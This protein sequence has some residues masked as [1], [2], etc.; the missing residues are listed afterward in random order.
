MKINRLE[1][2]D[3]FLEFQK[4]ANLI[5]EGLRECIEKRP[6]EYE[7]YPFYAFGHKRTYA[8]DEQCKLYND[9]LMCSILD[10]TYQRKFTDVLQMPNA[11]IIWIP[12]LT[13]PKAEP[14]SWLFK[15]YPQE[16]ITKVF[17]ILPEYETWGQYTDEK[18]C[19]NR[20]ISESIRM[21]KTNKEFLEKPEDDDLPEYV[22]EGINRQIGINK[23]AQ[24]SLPNDWLKI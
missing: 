18:M 17:W 15:Y 14:N 1:T 3:R 23:Q 9:D 21:F 12:R 5:E 20:A 10:P 6:K 24:A 7:N 8:L 4:Q 16:D 22:I 19:Q 2:H 11:R 13:K